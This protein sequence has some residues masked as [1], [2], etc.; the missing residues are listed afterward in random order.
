MNEERPAASRRRRRGRKWTKPACAREGCGRTVREHP[1]RTHCCFLCQVLDREL[2][3]A[4]RICE[5]TGDTEHWLAV[6][7]LNDALSEY[8]KSDSRVYNAALSVGLT[9]EQWRAMKHGA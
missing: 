1:E 2:T 7:T 8:Y 3:R 9:D 5:A 6:V 4:Q